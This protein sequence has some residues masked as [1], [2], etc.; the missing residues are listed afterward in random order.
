[1]PKIHHC[2]LASTTLPEWLELVV[3]LNLSLP[4]R[5]KSR[6]WYLKHHCRVEPQAGSDILSITTGPS[7]KPAVMVIISLSAR[8]TNRQCW[9]NW[10]LSGC[11][12]DQQWSFSTVPVFKNR[13]WYLTLITAG[14][15]VPVQNLAVTRGFEPA[16]LSRSGVVLQFS[17]FLIPPGVTV[18]P[19]KRQTQSEKHSATDKSWAEQ[20]DHEKR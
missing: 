13:Q 18:L 6:Q 5:G 14:L 8:S 16:I 2:R 20:I 7:H 4:A 11:V 12:K 17:A 1:M 15:I 9:L 10:T 3:L 19:T